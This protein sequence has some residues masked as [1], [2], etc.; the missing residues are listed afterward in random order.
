MKD[1][2]RTTLVLVAATIIA[3]IA[4]AQNSIKEGKW[5]MTVVNKVEGLP[6][7]VSAVMNQQGMTTTVTQCITNKN[8]VPQPKELPTGCSMPQIQK[9]G[10]SI[11]YQIT[12]DNGDFQ[13]NQNGEM[14]YTGDTM[15]GIIKSHQSVKGMN[16]DSSMEISGRYLGPC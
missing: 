15:R 5:E 3:T 9:N 16:I 4:N 6:P 14:T 1:I 10:D 13:M 2:L 12:C 8:P 7:E 11:T